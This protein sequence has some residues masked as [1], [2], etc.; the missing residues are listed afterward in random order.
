METKVEFFPAVIVGHFNRITSNK[1]SEEFRFWGEKAPFKYDKLLYS[2]YY[3]QDRY[4]KLKEGESYFDSIGYTGKRMID[5][6]GFQVK[7]LGVKINPEDVITCYAREKADVG[8][9][10][11]IPMT[12]EYREDYIKNN[13]ESVQYM[14]A[15]KH[16]C[17]NTELLDVSHGFKLEDRKRYYENFKEFNDK[18][19]GWAVGLNK[20]L[21]PIFNAW[22]FM[23]LIEKD[24]SLKNKRFHFLGLTGNKNLPMLF[25]LGKLNLVKYISFD[26]TSY[27]REGIMADMRNP[28]L[29]KEKLSIGNNAQSEFKTNKWCPC[30]VCQSIDMNIMSKDSNY[31]I[32]HNLFWELKKMEFFDSFKT[33][34]G[35]KRYIMEMTIFKKETKIAIKFIDYCLEHGIEKAEQKFKSEFTI[36]KDF[37]TSNLTSFM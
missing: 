32:L 8:M 19:D 27:G 22:S 26:S 30:P 12:K 28:S 15:N 3:L 23:Y 18:L 35:L 33:A 34:D 37:N 17:P 1:D 9:I 2:F 29:F 21:N 10:L 11:D 7:T 31:I 36:T 20:T 24:P 4:K 13:R 5:S 6:G 25:Y 14:I 16:K